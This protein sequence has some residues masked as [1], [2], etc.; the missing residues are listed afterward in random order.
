ME[1]YLIWKTLNDNLR[2]CGTRREENKV[3]VD[4]MIIE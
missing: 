1:E 3:I 4:Y 2:E